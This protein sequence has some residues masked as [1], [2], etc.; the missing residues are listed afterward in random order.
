MSSPTAIEE[1]SETK[2]RKVAI[3]EVTKATILGH[4][5]MKPK[6]SLSL[7]ILKEGRYSSLNQEAKDNDNDDKVCARLVLSFLHLIISI[8]SDRDHVE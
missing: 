8:L 7:P 3:S 6:S 4:F 5:S 1:D 2:K